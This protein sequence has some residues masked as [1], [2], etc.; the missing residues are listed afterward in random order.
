MGF[1]EDSSA[2]FRTAQ[3]MRSSIGVVLPEVSTPF[4]YA[5]GSLRRIIVDGN[6]STIPAKWMFE[7]VRGIWHGE[8]W[9]SMRFVVGVNRVAR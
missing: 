2:P 5:G 7:N 9:L 8:G 3:L 1:P 4:L 6:S